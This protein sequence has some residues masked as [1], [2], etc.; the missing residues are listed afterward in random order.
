VA[1]CCSPA[2][3]Q[4]RLVTERIGTNQCENH[5]IIE[6][7]G[8]HALV[9]YAQ[10][11]QAKSVLVS[12]VVKGQQPHKYIPGDILTNDL[13]SVMSFKTTNS[14]RTSKQ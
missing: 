14:V 3:A 5:L 13:G 11:K 8:P 1:F 2:A 9:G 4:A 12:G 7:L 6:S 10:S